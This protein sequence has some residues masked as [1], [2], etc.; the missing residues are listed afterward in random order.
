MKQFVRMSLLATLL[1]GLF[2][3][4]IVNAVGNQL[5][6]DSKT[7]SNA[8]KKWTIE[9][10]EPVL[11]K[12]ATDLFF[13]VVD[14][15]KRRVPVTVQRSDDGLSVTVTPSQP[16][17]LN[18]EYQL[19]V[20]ESVFSETDTER[21]G[22]TIVMPFQIDAQ[23]PPEEESTSSNNKTTS[24]KSN[25]TQNNTKE[26]DKPSA[27]NINSIHGKFI[28]EI[29]IKVSDP[30]IARIVIGRTDMNYEGANTYTLALAGIKTNEKLSVKAYDAN[31]K[32]VESL[33]YT[34][35]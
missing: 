18:Q 12:S 34:V 8:Y 29:T 32:L 3:T 23:A 31:G 7:V 20:E 21:L 1:A 27:L 10:N 11:A 26:Q 9:F 4:P 30:F 35:K 22:Q 13:Y 2:F 24:K 17:K 16:Y 19:I 5:L 6:W 25:T 28:T 33:N 15:K 14:S